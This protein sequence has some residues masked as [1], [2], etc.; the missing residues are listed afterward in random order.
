MKLYIDGDSFPNILK[1]IMFRAIERLT[2]QTFVIANKRV[3]IGESKYIQYLVVNSGSDEADNRIV[4][5]AE[6]GDLVIT[7]DI[8]LADRVITKKAHAINHRGELYTIENIKDYLSM[9]NLMQEFREYG[10]ETKGPAPFS[11]KDANGFANQLNKFLTKH[12][13]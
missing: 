3:S 1:P 2:L 12:F 11:R 5:M 6:E 4:E 8:P 13:A 7:A 10:I 9:R